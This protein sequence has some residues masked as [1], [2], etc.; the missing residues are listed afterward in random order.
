MSSGRFWIDAGSGRIDRAEL[1]LVTGT[2]TARLVTTYR[3]DG[4]LGIAVPVE[5]REE[6]TVAED[7]R[8][9][10]PARTIT[11]FARYS[12]F[13]RFEVSAE[14]TVGALAAERPLVASVVRRAGEYVTRFAQAFSNVVMEEHYVQ[15]VSAGVPSGLLRSGGQRD[16]RSDLLLL[17]VGGL[18]EWQPFRDVFEIGGSPVRDRDERLAKLFNQ[19]TSAIV[20]RAEAIALESSRYNIG[21]VF[22]TVNTPVHT[23]LFLRPALQPR[24]DFS[25]D[26]QDES[27]RRRRVDREIRGSVRGRRSF[28][29]I[30]IRTCRPP[31]A[32]GSKPATD[33]CSDPSW[34]PSAA[35]ERPMSRRR[36]V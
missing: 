7:T 32:S 25:L 11:G 2:M 14:S 10:Q 27:Y 19:P 22:R 8:T 31:G 13:R 4:R 5:M 3:D 6:Y 9:R 15:N 35:R 34:S 21:S 33:A 18:V 30:V 29:A 28:A 20:A 1:V 16:L 36:S 12:D 24:F 26:R 23:L 17:R